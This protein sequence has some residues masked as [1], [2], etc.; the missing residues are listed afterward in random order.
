MR[1][2]IKAPQPRPPVAARLGK[3]VLQ[4]GAGSRVE[5]RCVAAHRVSTPIQ[6]IHWSAQRR[7]GRGAV[8]ARNQLATCATRG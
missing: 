2:Q 1:G 4:L 6:M 7:L 8:S 3:S 5:T